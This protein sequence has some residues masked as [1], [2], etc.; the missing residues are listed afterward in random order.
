MS[1]KTKLPKHWH[2]FSNAEVLAQELTKKILKLAEKAIDKRGAF[3]FITAGGTTPNRCYQLLSEAN[4]D[5]KNWHIYM[6]DERVLPFL[7]PDRNSQALLQHWLNHNDIPVKQV[8]FINTEAGIEKSAETYADII[9]SIERFDLAL[10][11][12]GEDGHTASLFPEHEFADSVKLIGDEGL[13]I[14]EFDSP[15]PPSERVSLNYS[16]FS[17]VK[18]VCKVITGESK[19]PVV[20]AWLSGEDFPIAKVSGKHDEVWL[21]SD[22]LSDSLG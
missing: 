10:L 14:M 16:A 1:K 18:R 5:W 15:K 8:H 3:H 6:G 21:S 12:M 4:A 7:N 20:K 19:A 11:G 22:S 9:E 2:E 17:K 13:V